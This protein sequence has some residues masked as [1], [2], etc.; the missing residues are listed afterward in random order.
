MAGGRATPAWSLASD[1]EVLSL[2]VSGDRL[3]IAHRLRGVA[4]R[5]TLDGRVIL[6]STGTYSAFGLAV[7]PDGREIAVGLW[8][9]NVLQVDA[10][11]GATVRTLSG[12]GRVVGSVRYTADSATLVTASRDGATRLWDVA[13]GAPLATLASRTAGAESLALLPGDGVAIGHDDGAMV[14]AGMDYYLRHVA[15]NAAFQA[16]LGPSAAD[17]PRAG[18]VLAWARR[19]TEG[20]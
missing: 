17:F 2:D 13:T 7:R 19:T 9:G 3:A 6:P 1:A 15:G 11:T 14:A 4:I 8:E 16:A 10:A 5:S 20:R 18:E 12:H